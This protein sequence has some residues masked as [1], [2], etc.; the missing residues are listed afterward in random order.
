MKI[1]ITGGAGF[2]GSQ[3]AHVL[4]QEH[5][6]TVIDNM[7]Y[8]SE[9]NLMSED[10]RKIRMIVEDIRNR[11]FVEETVKS[12][13]IVLHFAAIAPLPDNQINPS[14]AYEN[15]VIGTINVL[16]SC[17]RFG[18]RKFVL[19][20]TSAVYENNEEKV[21]KEELQISPDLVYSMTKKSAE[22]VTLAYGKCYGLPVSI[23]RFFNVYGPHQNYKR[24]APPLMGYITR[25]LVSGRSP[26]LHSSGEQRRD[27]VHVNDAC[28]LVEAV[29]FSEKSNGQIFNACGEKTWSVNEIF[30]LCASRLKSELKPQFRNSEHL[31]NGYDDLFEGVYS[32]SK[33][34]VKKET[35]KYS[36]GSFEKANKI[37][38]WSPVI[39]FEWG[40]N[41]SVDAMVHSMSKEKNL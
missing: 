13:D 38:G 35:E 21:L 3:C 18:I 20:S 27:Y 24:K 15:N 2:I 11:E 32:L 33:S 19:A 5:E 9:D 16:E 40:V 17:R 12:N 8:G 4:S 41:E 10:G 1:L 29:A 22:E 39:E 37:L 14:L 25:E 23:V 30:E 7:S 31:W 28:R 36:I 6:I 34:R 26:I